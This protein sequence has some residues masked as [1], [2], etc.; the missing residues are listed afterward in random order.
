MYSPF[1]K[2]L[3]SITIDDLACLRQVSE[4]WFVEYKEQLPLPKD[5]AKSVAAF[6]NHNGGWL[7]IGVQESKD[8]QRTAAAFP[9]LKTE[10][11]AGS[12]DSIRDAIHA[13]I[14]PTPHFEIRAL[15][16]PSA[17]G[18]AA[19]SKAIVIV[20]IP[21]GANPPYVH[22]S[23]RIYRRVAD[24]AEPKPE[25]DRAVIDMLIARSGQCRERLRSVLMS[26]HV[27]SKGESNSA[28]L[29]LFFLQDLFGDRGDK[30]AMSFTEFAGLAGSP[31]ASP[32]G[33]VFD[34][35]FTTSD[36]FVARHVG[37]NDPQHR[38]LTWQFFANGT[39]IFTLPLGL[40]DPRRNSRFKYAKDFVLALGGLRA[41]NVIDANRFLIVLSALYGM[42]VAAINKGGITGPVMSKARLLNVWCKIPFFDSEAFLL[43]VR[44]HGVPVCQEESAFAP[45]GTIPES[46]LKL[47][48]RESLN[49]SSIDSP[50]KL[51]VSVAQLF[52]VVLESLGV[53][54]DVLIQSNEDLYMAADRSLPITY[55]Q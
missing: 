27:L 29:Q 13:H 32:V 49:E 12:V 2:D 24:S 10:T 31:T 45:S 8:G 7:F 36:G 26:E 3:A 33:L 39:S 23:G 16:G 15:I 50:I 34:N 52:L 51:I 4:G 9:G 54:G 11:V 18:G 37:P 30:V 47:V 46:F 1:R 35:C 55:R 48:N 14:D 17:D 28:F 38:L 42:H 5:I 53:P 40:G 43:H 20:H 41:E 21:S 6:A 22:S 44:K 19:S 25:S